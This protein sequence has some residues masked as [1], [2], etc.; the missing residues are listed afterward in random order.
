MKYGIGRCNKKQGYRTNWESKSVNR[1]QIAIKT[2][3]KFHYNKMNQNEYQKKKEVKE[4]F[5]KIIFH[6]N[7][8]VV[9]K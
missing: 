5:Q 3:Y 8:L 7:D 9:L 2:N 1:Q 6:L 4:N